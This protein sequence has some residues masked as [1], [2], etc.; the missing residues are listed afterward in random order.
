[1]YFETGMPWRC[2]KQFNGCVESAANAKGP[3][4][5]I[6]FC[7]TKVYFLNLT[8]TIIKMVTNLDT[9]KHFTENFYRHFDIAYTV[10]R[11]V[12]GYFNGFYSL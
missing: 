7:F 11:R 12:L 2:S 8:S 10:L 4:I 5:M 1:V 9:G 3:K 6:I